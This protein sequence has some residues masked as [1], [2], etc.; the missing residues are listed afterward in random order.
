MHA[1]NLTELIRTDALDGLLRLCGTEEG[2]LARGSDYDFF[3]AVCRAIPLLQGHP[4]PQ[5]LQGFLED[6][7]A[8]TQPLTA[9]SAAEIWRRVSEML[10]QHPTAFPV[11]L[12]SKA[13]PEWDLPSLT[14]QKSTSVWRVGETVDT[15]ATS[16]Q[17]WEAELRRSLDERAKAGFSCVA[18]RLSD[19][20]L[21]Q[22]PNPFF[23]DRSLSASPRSDEDL[24]LLCAQRVR[25]FCIEAQRRA[26]TLLLE[27][28]GDCRN[29]IGFLE[30]LEQTVGLPAILAV[31][32]RGNSDLLLRFAER[33]HRA[34]VGL[35]IDLARFSDRATL[36]R[37]V[38]ALA[39]CYPL[40]RLAVLD[41]ECLERFETA[42]ENTIPMRY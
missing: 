20:A 30:W 29:P 13:L 26:L 1:T 34:S 32:T 9:D 21:G 25:F 41:G 10:L 24:A 16:W 31:A 17:V 39:E 38:R 3:L 33:E 19:A 12:E 23:V 36:E 37:E 8:I 28:D 7:F 6:R 18:L 14:E 15:A 35:A 4:F 40:G 11:S 22:R 27:L 42:C 2:I 5:S